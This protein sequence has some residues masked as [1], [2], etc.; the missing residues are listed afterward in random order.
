MLF[1]YNEILKIYNNDYQI[2]KAISKHKLYK[3]EKGIY[4][5]NHC[6]NIYEV[7][8]KKYPN[9]VLVGPTALYLKGYLSNEPEKIYMGT[10]RNALRISDKRIKQQFYAKLESLVKKYFDAIQTENDRFLPT[11]K[12]EMLL[13]DLL[14]K[15]ENYTP[16]D[17]NEA[18]NNFK[19][20]AKYLDFWD[21]ENELL[22]YNKFDNN[23]KYLHD[24]GVLYRT[25]S[26]RFWKLL[27]LQDAVRRH[28]SYGRS[29][30]KSY[31]LMIGFD[32]K[33]EEVEQNES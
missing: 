6:Y 14:R 10:K 33:D 17:F 2:K 11:F 24:Q 8:V 31:H 7:V 4:S 16:E 12:D 18:L 9:A 1:N 20:N 30:I 15:K 29:I 23:E 21:I 19:Q 25:I 22:Q 28:K 5:N 26:R 3:V 32:K 13:V 27:C